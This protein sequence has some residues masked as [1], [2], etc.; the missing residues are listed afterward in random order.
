VREVIQ[1]TRTPDLDLLPANID[2][3]AAEV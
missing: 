1:H 3:A 2:L